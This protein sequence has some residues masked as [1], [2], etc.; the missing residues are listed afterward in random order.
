MSMIFSENRFLVFPIEKLGFRP[1][2]TAM[3]I[4]SNEDAAIKKGLIAPS[5]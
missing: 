1:M 5:A 2:L 4:F 3:A